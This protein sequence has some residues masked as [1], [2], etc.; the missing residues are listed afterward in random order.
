M[1]SGLVGDWASEKV[2][3]WALVWA[4]R[5]DMRCCSSAR[6]SAQSQADDLVL[7]SVHDLVFGWDAT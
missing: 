3:A 6:E 1:A 7:L 2:V 5:C 4:R